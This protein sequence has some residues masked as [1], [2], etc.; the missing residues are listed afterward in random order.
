MF[1]PFGLRTAPRIFN[2]F[3][4]ALHWVL[5]TL[6]EWNVTHY[7]DNFLVVFPANTDITLY[8]QQFDDILEMFGISK[9]TEKDSQ[10]CTVIHLGFEFDSINMEVR[11]PANKKTRAL[12]SVQSLLST[13]HVTFSDLEHSLGFLSHCC[14]VVPLGRPFLRSLFALLHHNQNRRHFRRIHLSHEAKRDLRW[15]QYFLNSWSSISL[16]QISCQ[17]HDVATDAS[18]T[19]GIGGVYKRQVFSRRMLT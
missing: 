18:G 9:A 13:K 8:S 15:W 6:K 12:K 17:N 16:I 11:L 3:A 19:K 4:E 2:Y 1:L 14:Q 5:E 10:G 7:L